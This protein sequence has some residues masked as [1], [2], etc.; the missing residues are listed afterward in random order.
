MRLDIEVPDDRGLLVRCLERTAARQGRPVGHV[1]L[2]AVEDYL[3][4]QLVLPA[5]HLGVRRPFT[6]ADIYEDA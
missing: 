4:R 1:V 6:R 3:E 5:L 2:D